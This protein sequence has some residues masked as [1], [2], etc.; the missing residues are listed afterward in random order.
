MFQGFSPALFIENIRF[1]QKEVVKS[2]GA[3]KRN[4]NYSGKFVL[5]TGSELHQALS[6]RALNEGHGI[7]MVDWGISI[8]VRMRT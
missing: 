8:S 5:R 3:R 6:V 4:K 1:N 7:Q 2:W